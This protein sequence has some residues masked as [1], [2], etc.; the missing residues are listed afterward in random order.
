M[1]PAKE[2]HPG[3]V[4]RMRKPHPCGGQE[5][6]ITRVGADVGLRCLKCN[7][8]V[9]LTRSNFEKRVKEIVSSADSDTPVRE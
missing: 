2:F 5:W 1:P 9:M 4:V 3:D 8:R 7:R 6:A